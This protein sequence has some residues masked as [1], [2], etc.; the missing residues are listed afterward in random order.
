MKHKMHMAPKH[1]AESSSPL[2]E[3]LGW[4]RQGCM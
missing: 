3:V 1:L 2:K 4:K